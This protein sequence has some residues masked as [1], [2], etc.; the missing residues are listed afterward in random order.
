MVGIVLVCFDCVNRGV[1]DI[2]SRGRSSGLWGGVQVCGGRC[3]GL[4][5]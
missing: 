3:A 4:N 1:G 5:R 2:C